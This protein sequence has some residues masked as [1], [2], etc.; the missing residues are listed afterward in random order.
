MQSLHN[1]EKSAFR[2]GEYVGY[3]EGRV[4]RIKRDG[5]AGLVEPKAL[6]QAAFFGDTLLD[7]SRKLTQQR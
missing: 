6:Q 5:S 4:Y 1:I 3:A 2:K 7:F